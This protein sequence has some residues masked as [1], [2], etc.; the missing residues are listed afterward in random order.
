MRVPIYNGRS[1]E[2]HI[3]GC[4][5]KG[6]FFC[7][8][9]ITSWTMTMMFHPQV[10]RRGRVTWSNTTQ[11]CVFVSTLHWSPP[12]L[13]EKK[14]KRKWMIRGPMSRPLCVFVSPNWVLEMEWEYKTRWCR[15]SLYSLFW[16]SVLYYAVWKGFV[17]CCVTMFIKLFNIIFYIFITIVLKVKLLK[18]AFDDVVD[19]SCLPE[20]IWGYDRTVIL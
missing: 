2:R 16:C 19:M 15:W 1:E 17:C 10:V 4:T 11:T 3:W 6:A 14:K 7:G 12:L 5:R 9:I 18:P 13:P 20:I 8:T